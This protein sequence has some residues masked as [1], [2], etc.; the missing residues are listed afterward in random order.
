[1]LRRVGAVL[2]GASSL[3]MVPGLARAVRP[4]GPTVGHPERVLS[5]LPLASISVAWLG[6]AA[7]LWRPLPVTVDRRVRAVLLPLSV[8]A[9]AGGLGLAVAGRLTLGSAY[10]PSSTA[11]VRLAPGQRLVTEGPYRF[12]RHPMYL[13]LS[14][15]ALGALGLY[16]TWTT[17]LFVAQLPVLVVRARLEEEALQAEFG[18]T[19]QA[20]RDEVPRW[21]PKSLATLLGRRD[22]S[23][24]APGSSEVDWTAR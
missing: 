22:Y 18:A 3:S 14:L 5:P 6:I 15:A 12:V 19:W 2:A 9:Y 10:R 16:R 21:R 17:L 7:L 20:Y 13:G 4:V 24:G 1:M 23:P 11:G 8:A